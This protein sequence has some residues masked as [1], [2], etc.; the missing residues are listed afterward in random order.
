MAKI[1]NFAKNFNAMLLIALASLLTF[2]SCGQNDVGDEAL[3]TKMEYG[4]DYNE[5]STLNHDDEYGTANLRVELDKKIGSEIETRNADI[6]AKC[7]AN[8]ETDPVETANMEKTFVSGEII[9][10]NVENSNAHT[11]TCDIK[12][13]GTENLIK[14]KVT[15]TPGMAWDRS[16]DLNVTKIAVVTNEVKIVETSKKLGEKVC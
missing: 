16:Y 11:F 8:V 12:V 9:K 4:I 1:A 10:G 7:V 3:R 14:T 15:V 13:N 6:T 2:V 5:K